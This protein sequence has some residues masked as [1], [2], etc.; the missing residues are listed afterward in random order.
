[1]SLPYACCCCCM[2]TPHLIFVWCGRVSRRL[3][4]ANGAT[5]VDRRRKKNIASM[6]SI[7]QFSYLLANFNRT[8]C[9]ILSIYTLFDLIVSHNNLAT[10]SIH[11]FFSHPWISLYIQ[12]LGDDIEK[13]QD[14][15]VCIIALNNEI[16][17]STQD[18]SGFIIHSSSSSRI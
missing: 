4:K 14:S 15:A 13:N 10:I 1:M 2:L 11:H 16:P 9:V 12:K 5:Y 3:F 18:E 6:L 17:Y 7:V 8:L